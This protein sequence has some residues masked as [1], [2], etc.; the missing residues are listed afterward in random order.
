MTREE[1]VNS[2]IEYAG[3]DYDESDENQV[4][5]LEW[6][7]DDAIEEVVNEMCPYGFS[8]DTA[9]EKAIGIALSRYGATIRRIA[10]FHFDKQGKEG[11]TTFYESGQTTSYEDGGTPKRYLQHIVPIAK[12]V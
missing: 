8:T 12:I 7:V 11:V 10:M 6:T 2:I 1:L 5:F 3:D 4:S 9:H